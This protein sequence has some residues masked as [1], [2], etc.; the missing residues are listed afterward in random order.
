M[1]DLVLISDHEECISQTGVLENYIQ[2]RVLENYNK[3][4]QVA[5]R[6]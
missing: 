6:G 1:D 2:T 5:N 3:H 4:W